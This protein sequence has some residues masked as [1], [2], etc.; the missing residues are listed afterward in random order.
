M[1]QNHGLSRLQHF[2]SGPGVQNIFCT[3]K[4]LKR[5]KSAFMERLN[6]LRHF[7]KMMRSARYAL[8]F[9]KLEKTEIC[10]YGER[11]NRLRHFARMMRSARYALHFQKVEKTEICAGSHDQDSF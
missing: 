3:L 9:Q 7:A 4:S 8:H 6:R 10:I 11:L 2:A 1:K 5:Q